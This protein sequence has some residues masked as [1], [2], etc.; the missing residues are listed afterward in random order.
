MSWRSKLRSVHCAPLPVNVTSKT[1][2]GVVGVAALNPL[3][4][5]HA[6][7]GSVGSMEIPLTN[8]PGVEDVSI[9]VNVT[10]VAGSALAFFETK[11]RPVVVA[12]QRVELSLRARSTAATKP[13]ARVP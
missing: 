9:R 1:C 12:A 4:E 3:N 13:P 6:W 11:T 8:R 7:F 2:P 10:P 5:I